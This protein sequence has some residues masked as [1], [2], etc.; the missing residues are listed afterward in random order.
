[1]SSSLST[2]ISEFPDSPGIYLFLNASEEI[3]YVGKATSL[4]NRVK[5]YFVFKKASRP[6]ETMMHEVARI[7]YKVGGSVLEAIVMEGNAI[8]KYEPKYNVIGKDNKSF[9]YIVIS[10]S[11]Y[12]EVK[13]LRQREWSLLQKTGE[14]KKQF[15]FSFGPFP[16]LNAKEA[17]R[18]L[19]KMFHFST[20]RPGAKRPC[21]YFEMGQCFGV[22]TSLISS[23]E[24]QKKAIRPLV[25]FLK[26][27]KAKL[28]SLFEKQ[29]GEY[30]KKQEYEQAARVRD[31]LRLLSKIQDGALI[32]KSFFEDET[33]EKN[34]RI[35]GY[36]ISHFSGSSIVASMVVFDSHGPLKSEYRKFNIKSLS[37]QSDV[38]SLDEVLSRRMTHKEWPY[39]DIFL[40][41]GGK[42]QVSRAYSVISK[43]IPF[44]FVLGIAKGPERKKN[45]FIFPTIF[46]TS[47]NPAGR[48]FIR[49]VAKHTALLIRV[50]DE[51]HHFAIQFQKSKRKI[52]NPSA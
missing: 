31:Q 20:C 8:K 35:E 50:R 6:I 52:K 42:P 14:A 15:S 26:G 32:N 9:N 21:L 1:M 29:M 37:N 44:P 13:T 25:L 7:E 33:E 11:E 12:P 48:S 27:E 34:I 38:D 23:S 51:A 39:P 16:G 43:L 46:K 45:D 3:I 22:C 41:D 47:S 40:I 49:Y 17:F 28:I 5:S 18:L 19:R 2:F 36:D 10:R 24:Y 4:K 30:T